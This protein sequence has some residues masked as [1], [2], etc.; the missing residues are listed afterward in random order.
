MS[1]NLPIPPTPVKPQSKFKKFILLFF[2]WAALTIATLGIGALVIIFT[3]F[4]PLKSKYEKTELELNQA[5]ATLAAQAGLITELTTH[6]AEMQ[7][8]LEKANVRNALVKTLSFI[9]S[10][11]LGISLNDSA[12]AQLSLAEAIKALDELALLVNSDQKS[13]VA[14]MQDDAS[15]AFSSLKT[16]LVSAKTILDLLE[17]NLVQLEASLS[18]NP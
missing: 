4:L 16:D 13:I 1:E 8:T 7:I 2:R 18:T 11:N 17:K 5:N 3:L 14:T 9:R 10:A 6:D 12:G 15:K